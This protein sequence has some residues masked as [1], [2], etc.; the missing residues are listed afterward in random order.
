MQHRTHYSPLNGLTR[1]TVQAYQTKSILPL[2]SFATDFS[3]L[4][5]VLRPAAMSSRMCGRKEM[6]HMC[7]VPQAL[8]N[9][10]W[11]T[12]CSMRSGTFL[13]THC[14]AGHI[15]VHGVSAY[16]SVLHANASALVDFVTH[17]RDRPSFAR[18]LIIFEPLWVLLTFREHL[19]C[20]ES[21]D[22]ELLS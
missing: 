19:Y 6:R 22:A 16:H 12:I 18:A 8:S 1:M 10:V 21:F 3:S 20:W 7:L 5:L 4:Y 9:E 14:R 15:S 2:Y 17:L 13:D 11:D